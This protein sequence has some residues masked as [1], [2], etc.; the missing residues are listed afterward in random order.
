[1]VQSEYV[2]NM[3]PEKYVLSTFSSTPIEEKAFFFLNIISYNL[4]VDA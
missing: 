2:L 4:L 3:R 1:M